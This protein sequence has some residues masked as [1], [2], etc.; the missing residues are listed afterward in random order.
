MQLIFKKGSS[1]LGLLLVF[2]LQIVQRFL[3]EWFLRSHFFLSAV[4]L[5]A[6]WRHVG[7]KKQL[8]SILLQVGI[9]LWTAASLFHW[10]LFAFRNI[11]IGRPFARAQVEEV[12]NA[13]RVTVTVPRAWEV[14]AG[15]YI[16]LAI[17][18]AGIFQSHPFMIAWWEWSVTGL[19][20]YL[21]VKRRH[22]FTK[23][24]TGRI[25]K[26]SLAFIDGPYGQKHDFGDYGTVIMFATDI[27]IAGHMPFIKDL[28]RGY[29]S[30]EVRTRRIV[31][32]WQMEHE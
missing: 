31:V 3:Y 7:F 18:K 26:I 29:N 30:C 8:S 28:V 21:L 17:P 22:G 16:F 12:S 6:I 15:Q 4:A 27:G 13:L 32:V 9:Y 2:S 11:V 23:D 14:K 20:V 25:G 19:K 5:V 1:A 24:L 10:M